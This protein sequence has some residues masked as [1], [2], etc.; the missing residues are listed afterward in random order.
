MTG[1]A[2]LHAQS[3]CAELRERGFS[4]E[5]VTVPFCWDKAHLLQNALSWRLLHIDADLVIGT[6]F[7]SY[8]VKHPNKVIWLFHQ[9]R[10]VYDLYDSEYSEFGRE[11]GDEEIRAAVHRGDTRTIQ[12]AR[13][14]F[15]VS[16]NVSRR[17]AKYNGVQAEPLYHPSPFYRHLHF[18]EY[19]DF[20][21]LPTRLEL[22]KRP[23]L[24]VEAMRRTRSRVRCVIAGSGSLDAS[25][26][27]D[28][29]R[30]DLQDRV[31]FIGW[32]SDPVELAD[33][34]ARCRAVYYGPYD[35]DYGYVTLEAFSSRKPMITTADAGGVLEFVSDDETG[36][37]TDA[38]PQAIADRIDR[39]AESPRLCSRLGEAGHARIEGI[40]WDHVIQQ[41]VG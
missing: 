25:L 2:E 8:F 38:D 30:G 28:I 35:E 14:L 40:S 23:G 16:Q 1:G 10:A 4:V 6:K 15:S 29:E 17:L 5:L 11:A 33:L 41:L 12:E 36:Y 27:K 9:H 26:R 31:K 18:K 39:L 22:N 20:I 3:L 37:V 19:G 24:L 13:K 21:F 7:P 32:I 34:Y